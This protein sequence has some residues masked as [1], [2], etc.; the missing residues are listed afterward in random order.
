M[1]EVRFRLRESGKGQAELLRL[2]LLKGGIP[3]EKISEKEEKGKRSLSVFVDSARQARVTAEAVKALKLKGISYSLIRL[4]DSDWK[5][6][7]KKYF[8]PFNITRDIRIIP[9]WEQGESAP[10]GVRGLRLDTTSAFG[11]G[12]HATTQMVAQMIRGHRED[13]G[14]FLDIGTGSGI[15]SLIACAYGAHFIR[16]IDNDPQAVETAR[17]NFRRN[18]CPDRHLR[19]ADFARFA[20]ARRFSFVAANLFTEDL[21]KFK[22]RLIPLVKPGGW[23]AVSGISNQNYGSFRRRF[24]DRRIRAV[25]A[26][27]RRK[28]HAVL[29]QR[30]EDR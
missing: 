15:L 16:A 21:I 4:K 11:T 10:P 14:D 25:K 2:L 13:L 27:G 6:R 5:T 12:L 8:K 18:G 30:K 29:F 3:L 24:V 7:W 20:S 19:A 22:D 9:V 26:M 17:R 23:L 1:I 28:W